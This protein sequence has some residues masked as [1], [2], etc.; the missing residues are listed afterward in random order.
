MSAIDYCICIEE[1]A[2]VD[3]AVAL[4][5]AAH[6]GLCAAHIALCRHRSAEA[7]VSR[8][9][10]A[11]RE[12]RRV[13]ADRVDLGQRRR[14]ACGR[15]PCETDDGWVL[16]GS[17]TFTTH[18]RV[19]DVLVVDG[20][21]RSHGRARKG[22]SAFIVEKGD[23]GDVRGQERK[24]S[25]GCGRAT[26]ARCCSRTAACRRTSCSGGKG[27]DSSTRCR[28][29]TPAAS[30]LPRSP[31]AWPRAPTK[32]RS[33]YA[34]ERQAFGTA[35]RRFQA[36]QWK[37]AD[38]ATRIEAARLLTYRAAYLKDCGER[39]DARVVDGQAVR[40]RDRRAG[41]RRLRADPRRLRLREGL[42]GGEVLSRR[43]ADHHRRGHERNP[44][45]RDRAAAPGPP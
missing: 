11:R 29:S 24:T 35:D 45:A 40:Q 10:G 13:G 2:R 15:P 39:D 6:N 18:G 12:D 23:A 37:L 25:S 7:A 3:P 22:I 36:I 1:L 20:R 32:P 16:N 44:A 17:K 4:S 19:G 31:S 42:P 14:G 34:R 33:R 43:Q 26:R 27:A 21:Y 28:C 38:N 5:V 9:A 30:A 8:A 41:R